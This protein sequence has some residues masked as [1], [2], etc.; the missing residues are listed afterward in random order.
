LFLPG[1]IAGAVAALALLDC[2]AEEPIMPSS[3]DAI[4]IIAVAK[5]RRRSWLISA[6]IFYSDSVS[7]TPAFVALM[8]IHE[9]VLTSFLLLFSLPFSRVR[10]M[11][12]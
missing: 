7:E 4:V 6:I 11:V 8:A 9:I 5:K 3:E 10:F 12:A 2:A 1:L